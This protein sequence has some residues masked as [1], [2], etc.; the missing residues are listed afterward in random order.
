MGFKALFKK[1]ASGAANASIDSVHER[2][3]RL[4]SAVCAHENHVGAAD[5]TPID[6]RVGVLEEQ[7]NA[8]YRRVDA[9]ENTATEPAA[10]DKAAS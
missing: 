3:D 4:E 8:L 7:V 9:L 5:E 10:P 2:L 1:I 6:A